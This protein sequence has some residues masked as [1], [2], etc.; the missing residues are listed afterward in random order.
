M[1]RIKESLCHWPLLLEALPRHL[2]APAGA[3]AYYPGGLNSTNAR[4]PARA[5]ALGF[6]TDQKCR[7]P[8]VAHAPWLA[9]APLA[10]VRFLCLFTALGLPLLCARLHTSLTAQRAPP[11][12][13]PAVTPSA[14]LRSA[15]AVD[16]TNFVVSPASN[17]SSSFK[18][19]Y[20]TNRGIK[21]ADKDWTVRWPAGHPRALA[22]LPVQRGRRVAEAP[23]PHTSLAGLL[24]A[25]RSSPASRR[26]LP[27]PPAC[28]RV[29]SPSALPSPPTPSPR[30]CRSGPTCPH[31]TS[32]CTSR[33]TPRTWRMLASC[34]RPCTTGGWQC[35]WRS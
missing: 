23:P 24:P 17:P 34:G 26:P 31:L 9:V 35:P 27:C 29:C 28:A 18:D 14:V 32:T 7:Q 11:P 20:Y 10:Q 30:L 13:C 4:A 3:N 8:C 25:A 5:R 33:L 16:S 2:C 15:A 1:L 12:P 21:V 19:D 6:Y 22:R